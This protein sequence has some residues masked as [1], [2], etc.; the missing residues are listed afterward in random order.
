MTNC[1]TPYDDV[2]RTMLV[3]CKSLII[4]MVNE[5][6]GEHYTG[7]EKI[8]LKENEIF[9]RQQQGYLTKYPS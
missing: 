7:K 5:I 8:V 2:F 9:L 3:D 4:P 1:N 6:F